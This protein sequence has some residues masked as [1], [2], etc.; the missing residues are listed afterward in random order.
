MPV[1]LSRIYKT[2]VVDTVIGQLVDLLVS[3]KLRLG[4]RLPSELELAAQLGVGRNSIREAMKVLQVLGMI[5]RRQGDGSYIREAMDFPLD[6]F[7]LPLAAKIKS[8]QELLE[9]REVL[10]LG[11]LE[12]VL[13]RAMEG[14]FARLEEN[15]KQFEEYAYQVPL[16]K[17]EVVRID[18]NFHIS[19]IEIT[20]NQA[21]VQLGTIIM[22][23]FQSSMED[24]ITAKEGILHA[25]IAHKEILRAMRARDLNG[26]RKAVIDSLSIWKEYIRL[27]DA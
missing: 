22:R 9:L 26:A 6:S 15:I 1:V 19:I 2:N 25:V 13:L 8:A 4:E 14:D 11:V 12:L 24:H 20:Q 27:G 18:M 16:P 3:G 5:E 21:L 23:L 17:K 7:L 10:E